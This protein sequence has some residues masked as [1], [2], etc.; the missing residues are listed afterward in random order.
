[1]DEICEA[2]A[3]KIYAASRGGYAIFYEDELFDEMPDGADRN[4]ETLE[5]ALKKLTL[6]GYIDVKYAR[7]NAFCMAGLKQY[8]AVKQT[9]PAEN[10]NCEQQKIN[11]N[12][13][14]LNALLGGLFGGITG[15]II[16]I[17]L[18]TIFI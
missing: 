18:A 15:G 3:T 5:A 16:C 6:N 10:C 1:M 12:R 11:Y 17:L 2:L 13:I 4:R 8:E 14:T 9:T 7:G